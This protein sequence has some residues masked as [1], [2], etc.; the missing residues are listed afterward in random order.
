[1]SRIILKKRQTFYRSASG[2][3]HSA[4]VSTE[5]AVSPAVSSSLSPQPI[6]RLAARTGRTNLIFIS[7][8]AADFLPVCQRLVYYSVVVSVVVV[9]SPVVSVVPSVVV[10][11][12]VESSVVSVEDAGN[13]VVVSSV[14]AAGAAAGGST[15][16]VP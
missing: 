13:A 16:H 2:F 8:K 7:L 15:E 11:P 3:F 10:V 1:M 9:V 6:R 14:V 12:V 5:S 4:A